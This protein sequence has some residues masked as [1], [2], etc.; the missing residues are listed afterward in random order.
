MTGLL[1]APTIGNYIGVR[2]RASLSSIL[3]A[4]KLLPLGLLMCA[5]VMCLGGQARI[6]PASEIKAPGWRSD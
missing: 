1:A 4:V 6:I 2:S 5:G 3:A